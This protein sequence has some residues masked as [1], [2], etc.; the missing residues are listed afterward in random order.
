MIPMPYC[1]VSGGKYSSMEIGLDK[2]TRIAGRS[3]IKGRI[4][5]DLDSWWK[6]PYPKKAGNALDDDGKGSM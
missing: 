2:L 6:E 5:F 1:I 4:I 3:S